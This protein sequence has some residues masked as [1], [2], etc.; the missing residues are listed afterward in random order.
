MHCIDYLITWVHV[1]MSVNRLVVER[2]LPQFITDFQQ[3]LHVAGECGWVNVYCLGNKV[4]N[5]IDIG[6]RCVQILIFAV[7]RL[8]LPHFS[9]DCHKISELS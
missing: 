8:L 4:D 6:L 3:T 5:L 1:C 9:T 7:S 2:L